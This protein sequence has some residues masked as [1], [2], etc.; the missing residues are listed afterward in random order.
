MAVNIRS[1]A[2]ATFAALFITGPLASQ[3][4][5]KA[6]SHTALR[7]APERSFTKPSFALPSLRTI[8]LARREPRLLE[9]EWKLGPV[10]VAK[11]PQPLAMPAARAVANEL[12]ETSPP[13]PPAAVLIAGNF[14]RP[15]VVPG[16][17]LEPP[18]EEFPGAVAVEV[19]RLAANAKWRRIVEENPARLRAAECTGISAERCA[20]SPWTRWHELVQRISTLQGEERL[21]AANEGINALLSYASD[22]EVY[23]VGDHWATLQ[24]SMARG[25]GDCEDIAVAKMWLLN[26]AGI[27][28]SSMRLVVLRDTLRDLD[29]AVLSV[30]EHGHQY[31]LDNTAWKV[32]RADWMR[33]YRPI[34]ALSS[35][36]SWI[37]GTRVPVAPALQIAQATVP[38]LPQ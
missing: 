27:E 22:E 8:G 4:V 28:L 30:V 16:P 21:Q 23:G 9:L 24:E 18:L 19:S 34:Y 6:P 38:T 20:T 37:Y 1:G 14:A 10:A 36:Q 2:I 17:T 33:G 11:E 3:D 32:G 13:V 31:V 26:A 15:P 12:S 5:A 29:H 7:P 35:E 25:R